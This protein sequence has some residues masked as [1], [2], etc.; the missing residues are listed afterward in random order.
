MTG[1]PI[2]ASDWDRESVAEVL[3]DAYAVGCLDSSE[4]DRRSGSAYCA[5]TLDELRDL[6]ADLPPWLLERPAPLPSEYWRGR[7]PRRAFAR[8]PWCS[9]LMFA[10]FWLV[11]AAVAWVP[12]A[13]AP[14]ILGW[15]IVM[16]RAQGRPRSAHGRPRQNDDRHGY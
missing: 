1:Q 12:P 14:L 4:L 13:A 10:G 9:W 6:T 2:R 5:R 11:A 15:L 16:L 8:W 3:R 7:P